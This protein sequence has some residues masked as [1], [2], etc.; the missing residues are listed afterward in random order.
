VKIDVHNHAIPERAIE[1]LNSEP[2]FGLQIHNGTWR[3]GHHADFEFDRALD[4]PAA[5]L[6]QLEAR[7]LD[8]AVVSVAPPLFYTELELEPADALSAA[9]NR[10]LAEWQDAHPDRLRWMAQVPIQFPERAA[11][12]LVE[13]AALG[14]AGVEIPTRVGTRRLDEPEFE[15][16]W[17]TAERLG[18]TVMVH[19][20]G[21]EPYTGLDAFFLQNVIG[22]LLETTLTIERLI[23]AGVFDR[24]PRLIVLFAHGGGYFPFQAGRLR[25]ACTV[26]SE[27]ADAPR[28]PWK[29]RGQIVVDTLTHDVE[30]LRY[31]VKRMG[32][33]NVL[34]GTDLPFDMSTPEPMVELGNAVSADAV[35]CVAEDNPARLFGWR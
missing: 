29:F 6:T 19:P 14:A 31:L 26:R 34:V 18:S 35:R 21:N 5:K 23:C 2:V 4:D 33:E 17:S 9:T 15:V 3:G 8:A 10:G 32:V 13:Q 30:A 22:N 25:H 24:H 12:V 11:E 28:D 27:L 7:G 1:L 16:F 20:S